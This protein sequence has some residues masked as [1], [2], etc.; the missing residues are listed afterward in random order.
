M[1]LVD[2]GAGESFET[3]AHARV[4]VVE[5]V[6]FAETAGVDDEKMAAAVGDVQ[7]EGLVQGLDLPKSLCHEVFVAHPVS[8]PVVV[9]EI[10]AITHG[11]AD[12]KPGER[13]QQK[14]ERSLLMKNTKLAQWPPSVQKIGQSQQAVGDRVRQTK[15][16]SV[17]TE[18]VTNLMD[19]N[20][21]D[22][23][24]SQ[25]FQKLCRNT[26]ARG[27]PRLAE[28]KSRWSL[29]VDQKNSRSRDGHF[30]RPLDDKIIQVPWIL[31]DHLLRSH[32]FEQPRIAG[33]NQKVEKADGRQ[34][35]QEQTHASARAIAHNQHHESE[36]RQKR[37]DLGRTFHLFEL[38][39]PQALEASF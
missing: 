8:R 35:S 27:T 32:P 3:E 2:F 1:T 14:T 36:K 21:F 22:L 33:E 25:F 13:C 10:I 6:G 5:P 15:R 29:P 28:R 7:R 9:F 18:D 12:E 16:E 38:H 26:N 4:G 23:L 30:V 39:H 31:T 17:A 37:R 11:E 20:R 34:K 19:Q 24:W